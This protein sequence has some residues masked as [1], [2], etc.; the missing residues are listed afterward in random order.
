MSE[1][2]NNNLF[3]ETAEYSTYRISGNRYRVISR[4][5]HED[6]PASKM[7]ASGTVSDNASVTAVVSDTYVK[8]NST[9]DY[10]GQSENWICNN[11]TYGTR[12]TLIK[13]ENLPVLA[14]D[15]FVT[16]AYIYVRPS[17]A[18][19]ADNFFFTREILA[20]W[21]FST[22][23][24]ANI[25]DHIDTLNIDYTIC[26]AG[27]YKWVRIDVTDQC[28]KWY[29]GT[30][31]GIALMPRTVSGVDA[32]RLS[33]SGTTS[34][35]YFEMEY[36]SL[37]GIESYWDYDSQTVGRAGNGYVNLCSGNLVFAHS[38]TI[39]NGNRL[40]VSVSHY[41]NAC[42]ADKNDFFM[43][44]GWKSSLH[45]TLH[46]D[47]NA[48]YWY[49]DGDGTSHAFG[50]DGKDESGLGLTL[51]VNENDITV[52]DKGDN[53]MTFPLV[54][55]GKELISSLSDAV[56][57]TIT[58]S[59]TGMKIQSVTDGAG[60]V[61]CFD[62]AN[63]LLC[64]I[65][66]PWQTASACTRFSYTDGRLTSVT[67]EDNKQSTF[68]YETVGAFRLLT[69]A[70]SSSGVQADYTYTNFDVA[71]GLPHM[72]TSAV[73]SAPDDENDDDDSGILYASN[74]TYTYENHITSVTDN[75]SGKTMRYHFNDDGNT[76]S[77]DDE[78][79]FGR[80][81]EYDRSGENENAPVNHATCV[82]K[83]EKV[84]TNLLKDTSFEDGSSNWQHGG[85]GSYLRDEANCRFGLVSE[86]IQIS[87]N[88]EAYVYQTVALS[89]GEYTLSAYASSN[90]PK[91]FLRVTYVENDTTVTRES[92]PVAVTS[93]VEFSRIALSFSIPADQTVSCCLV[94]KDIAGRA[95][96]DC[97][98]LETGSTC[99]HYNMLHN[100]DFARGTG[101]LPESWSKDSTV[102][103][104]Y[105]GIDSLSDI[106][107]PDHMT[108]RA[109]KLYGLP[110]RTIAFYQEFRAY[111]SAGDPFSFGG[112][113]K[114][115]AKE[116]DS[117]LYVNCC[118]R[119]LFYNGAWST[120]GRIDFNEE[121]G[122][123]QFSSGKAYAPINYTRIRL[124]VEYK[125]QMN[126]AWFGQL[127]L[128]PEQFGTEYVYDTSGN[129]KKANTLYGKTARSDYDD[130]NNLTS[131]RA[132][133]RDERT[134][135]N[136]G[137]TDAEKQKHLLLDVISPLG[138]KSAYTYDAYGN[139]LTTAVSDNN[140]HITEI[141][142]TSSVYTADGNYIVSQT[143]ARGKTVTTV[144]DT[145]K[146]TTESVTDP[147]GQVV[148]YTYDT[149]R[150]VTEVSTQVNVN[151]NAENIVK[152]YKNEYTYNVKDRLT[153]VRHNTDGNTQ[154]DVVYHFGYDALGRQ[155]TVSVGTQNLSTTEYQ[156]NASAP[157]YGTVS[158]VTYGNGFTVHNEYDAF[159]R[160]TG[161]CFGNETDPRYV[162][163][164]NARGQAAWMKDNLLH[165]VTETE[166]DL[167]DRP[168]RIKTHENG[169]HLYTGEVAYDKLFGNLSEFTERIGEGY[170]EYKTTFGYDA[171]S[172]PTTLTY[173]NN[174]N[175]STV[176]YDG[177]GRVS[178]KGVKVNGHEYTTAFAYASGA[179]AGKTTGLI[180]G[181][182]Q[183]GENFAY[184][185]DDVGN[186]VS[187][188]HN[189][190]V[191][192][193]SYD[194][195][196]QLIR[197][198]DQDDPTSG[199]NGTTWTYEYDQGGNILSKKRYAYTE[200]ADLSGATLLETDTFSYTDTNWR[201]K[202][203]AYNG[204]A[205]TYDAIGNPLNDGTWA[206]T[207]INGRQLASMSKLDGSLTASF[208]YNAEGLRVQKTVNGVVIKYI[209]HG[210][211]ITH[212]IR[213]NDELHFFYDTSG[214]PAMVEWNNGTT[215]AKYAYVKNLQG[216]IIAIID[217]TG[218]EV[219]KY[220]YDAWGTPMSTSGTMAGTL[221]VLQPFRYRGYV[222]DYETGLYYLRSRYYN[223]VRNRFV[224][225]D[226][227]RLKESNL[228]M[229]CGNCPV[230]SIDTDGQESHEQYEREN[231]SPRNNKYYKVYLCEPF[232]LF[233][234]GNENDDND[235][236][237]TSI[238]AG[239]EIAIHYVSSEARLLVFY[240]QY[241]GY[242]NI[243]DHM[244]VICVEEEIPDYKDWFGL[245]DI[246]YQGNTGTI[247]AV[248]KNVQKALGCQP[249]GIYGPET[250][251][252]V[253]RIIE[254][255]FPGEENSKITDPVKFRLMEE[256]Y[257]V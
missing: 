256:F 236:R 8:K 106:S 108:G 162:F 253:M 157:N 99:N 174:S 243:R 103:S 240:G 16:K 117:E 95:W 57:N 250:K 138:T 227:S 45:Q 24:Y 197:V 135:Y 195:L 64:A 89:A 4:A 6:M 118:M 163:R 210:K 187:V 167:S 35:P 148:N 244:D 131:Y 5:G 1:A 119:V 233:V 193:Y 48:V 122:S 9:Q 41:Y 179:T 33:A 215:T 235:D 83:V 11:G 125:C 53:V 239:T 217:D 205:I 97:V 144:T 158:S 81:A 113:A 73:V 191:T 88:R 94:A 40:P 101:V 257:G 36:A 211:N 69:S 55:S 72:V 50:A 164:Y 188:T 204:A 251:K 171:E 14:S 128:Y 66:T 212:L 226:S 140:G 180:S 183:T 201:D 161:I 165:R 30:N 80:Y 10:S 220:T 47:N 176:A 82:S 112:W 145:D 65:R 63:D 147:N 74:T 61:T 154:N 58:V 56:G 79:G 76:V 228:F 241:E 173:G 107:A 49:T 156:T 166:Y 185:Y 52:K 230:C 143:D 18:P 255:L 172:R 203:T 186:I 169:M 12:Y 92:D 19:A 127:Y 34:A 96:F 248:T 27:K 78:L 224:N 150:R 153:E 59:S 146:G 7:L 216:D 206:Y 222:Y 221:G 242:I 32:I 129:C 177:L 62:Y 115:F 28:R 90:A 102:S 42:Q 44:Y 70:V 170:T 37:S 160:V 31:Y 178:E 20:D 111:G 105:V 109:V 181:I 68:S 29:Q 71:G 46:K 254:E 133:G 85:T 199:T 136:W 77:V 130:F 75:Y 234:D 2:M 124:I 159:N 39:M 247:L 223:P 137:A 155:T 38:D 120:G 132:P 91:A 238:P 123:W 3:S 26:K 15:C 152:E 196:G 121:Q 139:P 219:V 237:Y 194:P 214:S 232:I 182:T 116:K 23:T 142:E 84:V 17:S 25:V 93:E 54:T 192:A 67:Y 175:Q 151:S 110:G 149:L 249:D 213:G 43:G 126:N 98:Q 208:V 207:W 231:I 168:C 104:T 134:V 225:S 245:D 190:K 60:R 141:V 200:A 184:T 86:R 13:V 22:V 100:S 209:L 21:D 246:C 198:N 229:Y 202:L 114:A 51:T 252:H 218:T 87:A 189:G